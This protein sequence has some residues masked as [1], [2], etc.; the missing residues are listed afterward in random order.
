MTFDQSE[1]E[2]RCEW[3]AKGLTTLAPVSDVVIVVDVLSFSTAVDI[4]LSRGGVVLPYPLKGAAAAD[5]A[6]SAGAT[7]ANPDRSLPWSLSPASLQGMPGGMRLVLPSPNGA[8]MCFS[9]YHPIVLTACLRNATATAEAAM[10]LGET[11]AVIPA[12]EM[13]DDGTMRPSVE[14]LLGA[15]AVIGALQGSL[16]PEA[17]AAEAVFQS[18]RSS[19]SDALRMSSSGKELIDRGFEPDI[20][21]AADLDCSSTVARLV[22]R[23]FAKVITS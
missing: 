5:Y 13:W 15:G 22:N 1:F 4:A 21:L 3:G 8:A 19:L 9:A 17:R 18:L 7:L 14:D 2:I 20:D 10:R 12:G 6:A 11:F 16:S 23:E